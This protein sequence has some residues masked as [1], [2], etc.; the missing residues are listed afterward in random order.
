MGER[1][2]MKTKALNAWWVGERGALGGCVFCARKFKF[3][4]LTSIPISSALRK[5]NTHKPSR[6]SQPTQ[7]NIVIRVENPSAL[8]RTF[9][10]D[11]GGMVW[12]GGYAR[13]GEKY[14]A[15]LTTVPA[16]GAVYEVCV[17]FRSLTLFCYARSSTLST[18]ARSLFLSLSLH[19]IAPFVCVCVYNG[20]LRPS[21]RVAP[22]AALPLR[23][24][25]R[26]CTHARTL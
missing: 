15:V 8:T 7:P 2:E 11:L 10:E 16:K 26:S 22:C 1:N 21:A 4:L 6:T 18:L 12:L 25:A 14:N 3:V 24:F 20:P 23:A 17:S 13:S 5:H 9:K 19:R